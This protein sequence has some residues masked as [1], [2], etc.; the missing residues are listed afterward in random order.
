M[1]CVNS[2]TGHKGWLKAVGVQRSTHSLHPTL[3]ANLEASIGRYSLGG[4]KV[5]T[6]P[7]LLS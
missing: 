2:N 4:Q 6:E 3:K 5:R 7:E 1:S